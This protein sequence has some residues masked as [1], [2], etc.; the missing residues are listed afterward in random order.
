[1]PLPGNTPH[2]GP[3]RHGRAESSAPK[4]P[5]A[6][7]GQTTQH[8][9]S[10]YAPWVLA[11]RWPDPVPTP[12]ADPMPACGGSPVPGVPHKVRRRE[13]ESGIHCCDGAAAGRG[14]AAPRD[15]RRCGRLVLRSCSCFETRSKRKLPRIGLAFILFW[16]YA[17]GSRFGLPAPS[18]TTLSIFPPR[19]VAPLFVMLAAIRTEACARARQGR[20]VRGQGRAEPACQQPHTHAHHRCT[21]R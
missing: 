11:A 3:Q 16:W 4:E 5:G 6:Y 8:C 2:T 15:L 10:A 17:V 20:A 9:R 18:P 13:G 19:P 12:R 1:M 14:A 7:R 21:R